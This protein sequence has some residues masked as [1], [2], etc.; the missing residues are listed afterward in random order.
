MGT[1]K[2]N[3]GG[4]KLMKKCIGVIAGISGKVITEKLHAK[5][6]NVALVAGKKGEAGTEIAD[7]V[8]ICDLTRKELV[9]SFFYEKNVQSVIIGTGH[10]LAFELAL[11]LENLGYVLSINPEISLLAKNK[12]L[13]KE[14]LLE[15]GF[16]TPKYIEI[17]KGEIDYGIAELL[18]KVSLPCVVKSAIDKNLP[19]K[20]NNKE[21]LEL[22][23]SEVLGLESD[24]LVEEYV[25]GI[26]MTVPVV[27]DSGK[28]SARAILVSYYNKAKECRLKGFQEEN[29]ISHKLSDELED[30]VASYCEKVALDTNM[31]GLCRVD[32]R[33]T[34]EKKIYVLEVNTVMVTGVHANQIEYGR[35]FLEKENVDF[36]EILVHEA[37]KKFKLL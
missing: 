9:H 24:V 13:Y 8:L 28:N 15:N 12:I 36:A 25:D 14:I 10:I 19:Q 1:K 6:F 22:S 35:C 3:L 11:Y 21:E 29:N 18:K 32:V 7:H 30:M 16:L 20:A 17:K 26:D 34:E 5:G 4:I 37:L 31:I 27:V 33:V 23:I 2:S